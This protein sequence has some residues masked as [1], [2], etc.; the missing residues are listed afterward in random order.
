MND[1]LYAFVDC[2]GLPFAGA[3]LLLV[4][5]IYQTITP[6][7]TQLTQP[8]INDMVADLYFTLKRELFH[9]IN[10]LKS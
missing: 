1:C 3:I 5:D 4:Q 6:L 8:T 7:F 10:T 9:R 2:P